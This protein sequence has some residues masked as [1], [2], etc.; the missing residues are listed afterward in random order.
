MNYKQ[1]HLDAA[2]LTAAK[3]MVLLKNDGGLLPLAKSGKIAVV[4]PLANKKAELFGG[5]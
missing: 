2:R 4:G 1:E 3:S 5:C